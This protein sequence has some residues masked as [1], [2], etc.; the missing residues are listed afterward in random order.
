DSAR[1]LSPDHVTIAEMLKRRGYATGMIGK[2]HLS[3]YRYH[4]AKREIRAT[5][6]GFD[7]E[8][9][10]EIKSVG[11]GANFWP[12]VFRTQPIRWLNIKENRLGK[13][14]YLVDRMNLEAVEFIQRHREKPFFLYL[15]H[16]APHSILNGKPDPVEKYRRKHPPGKSTRSRCYICQDAGHEGDPLNHWAADHNPHLAAMLQSIDEG[17]GMIL[18]KLDEL[19]LADDTLIVFTSDNGGETHVT[20]NAPLRGGKSQLYEGGI[21]VPLV[22]RWPGKVPA[23]RN[24]AQPTVNVDFYPT[25]LAAAGIEKDARQQIDGV[26]ILPLL[27]D[28]AARVPREAIYWHYPLP[29]PH[30]LGGRSAGAIRAGDWKLIE[31]LETGNVELYDLASDEGEKRDRAEQMS[32]KADELR[33]KLKTWRREVGVERKLE[34][35]MVRPTRLRFADSFPADEAS[36]RWFFQEHWETANG[37]LV[38][39]RIEGENK[40]IFVKKPIFRDTAISLDFT[41]R[42]AKEIR[43]MTGGQG[44]YNAV[45]IIT[46]NGFRVTTARDESAPFYPTIHGECP[47]RFEANT[48][49]TML[50]EIHG[51]QIL[52]RTDDEHFVIGRHPILQR[53]REYFALQVDRPSAAFDN[54]RI[55]DAE[56]A[57]RADW[58]DRSVAMAR[59]QAARPWLP[60]EPA[61]H[62]KDLTIILRD[63]LYRTDEAYRKLVRHIDTCRAAERKA[64]PDVFG[65]IKQARKKIAEQRKALLKNDDRFK[66]LN[67]RINRLRRSEVEALHD[68]DPKLADLPTHLYKARL[69]RTRQSAA[70]DP[71]FQALVSKRRDLQATV[72]KQYPQ[73]FRTNESLLQESRAVRDQHNGEAKFKQLIKATAEAVRAERA[74]LFTAEPQLRDLYQEVYGR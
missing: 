4:K 29:K 33:T 24:C 73:L 26:S 20:S 11:N 72:A 70:D 10:S 35:L 12:Y 69:E 6:H 57:V 44:H 13:D 51:D 31:S 16:Y 55:H 32:A 30:F 41:F 64:Y 48:W 7:Q 14:E 2:W 56:S 34:P 22:V 66:D 19:K 39:N 59:N 49:Y 37:V 38:R 53:Q 60:R 45:V 63:R 62:Y 46:P 3:G 52:A 27:Q 43:V 5:D 17:V 74:Y 54:I 8:I 9:A 65:T 15:S 47:V 61:D 71:E 36:D 40:R 28:P 50:I 68:R 21:R 23:G 58:A 67:D 25:F 18:A 42:G 1:P